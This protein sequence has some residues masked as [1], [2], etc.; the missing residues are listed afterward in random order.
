[1]RTLASVLIFWRTRI[2][3][4]IET[5]WYWM[6]LPIAAFLS[7]FFPWVAQNIGTLTRTSSY[8]GQSNYDLVSLSKMGSW[9]LLLYISF[10]SVLLVNRDAIKKAP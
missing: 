10:A 6:P 4:R 7:S 8:A 3:F 5:G 9:Y 2:Y 1:M